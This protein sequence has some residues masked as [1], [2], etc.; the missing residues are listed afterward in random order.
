MTDNQTVQAYIDAWTQSIESISELVAALPTDAWNRPTECPG[1]SVRDV[2][3]HVIAVESELLGDPRPIHSL[4]RDLRHI[5]GDFAR[6]M[7]L[8][9]DKRRCHTA[10]EMTGEL[11]YTVIRRSRAL[12]NAKN[13]PDDVVRFPAGPA[14]Y[15]L[16]YAEL[17]RRRVFDVWV[18]EQDL[19]RAVGVPGNLDSPGAVVTRDFLLLGLPKVVGKLAGT[20]VGSTVAFDVTGPLEFLRTV[21]VDADGQASVDERVSLA[22]D[23]Q[24][25]LGWETYLRLACG[26]G[27]PGPVKIEG[28]EELAARILANFALT[29]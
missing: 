21:R 16:S 20:P 5:T 3:A 12:R 7:E 2:V 13:E 9:V 27:R 28:D 17:L 6:Y 11:D 15:E 18:H 22:P 29:P 19:R 4:P 8:P 23:V 1:W 10:P 24:F 14:S 26:R 25:T